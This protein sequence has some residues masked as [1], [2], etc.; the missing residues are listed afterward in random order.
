[1]KRLI[2]SVLAAVLIL[3]CL[4]AALMSGVALAVEEDI[5]VG[6]SVLEQN[7]LK[8]GAITCESEQTVTGGSAVT[9]S[10]EPFYGNAFIGWFDG[11]QKVSGDA[12][13]TF[14]AEEDV[15]LSARFDI[16]NQ[17][18]NGSL[19]VTAANDA[20]VSLYNSF[21][22]YSETKRGVA[23]V[24]ANASKDVAKYGAYSLE[25]TPNAAN[26][27]DK[28]KSL[29][30]FP[31]TVEKNKDY[32]WRFSYRNAVAG[33][34]HYLHYNIDGATIVWNGST[35]YD[36]D[37]TMHSRG[38]DGDWANDKWSW[39]GGTSFKSGANYYNNRQYEAGQWVD[40][41]IM[42]NSG[43]D[44]SVFGSS[45]TATMHLT[46][47]TKKDISDAV[48]L[49][50]LSFSEAV[51]NDRTVISHG[52]SV[53]VTNLTDRSTDAYYMYGL[54]SKG[55]TY[56]N[57]DT[58]KVFYPSIYETYTATHAEGKEFLGW[59]DEN[60]VLVA[61]TP[62]AQLL[63]T[64]KTY[65]PRYAGVPDAGEGGYI[66]F[67]G[68]LVTATPYYGNA[69]RGWSDGVN[70]ISTE[71]TVNQNSV[72][73]CTAIFE[74][75][76]LIIDGGFER[77]ETAEIYNNFKDY[78]SA[79]REEALIVPTFV[80]GS[81]PEFG[82]SCLVVPTNET[83]NMG[84]GKQKGL[85]N[86]PV[87]VEAGKTYLWKFSYTFTAETYNSAT[88]YL[89]FSVD[90]ETSGGIP[91]KDTSG[92]T[93]SFHYEPSGRETIEKN[94]WAWGKV[95]TSATG[96]DPYNE[97]KN[98]TAGDKWVNLYVFFTPAVDGVH[99]LSLGTHYNCLSTLVFDNMSVTAVKDNVTTSKAIAGENGSVRNWRAE[100]PAYFATLG[101]GE[102]DSVDFNHPYYAYMMV[103]YYAVPDVGYVFDGW[104][105][106]D[107]LV[108]TDKKLSVLSTEGKTYTAKFKI[109][110]SKYS[111]NAVIEGGVPFGGYLEGE[112]QYSEITSGGSVTFTAKPY[113]GNIFK[114]WYD[115]D[116]LL[117]T[118][119][120]FEYTVRANK[121]ITAKFDKKNLFPDSGAENSSDADLG[122]SDAVVSKVYAAT[123]LSSIKLGAPTT[124]ITHA[125][126]ALEKNKNYY[127]STMWKGTAPDYIKL[128]AADGSVIAE[129]KDFA[130]GEGWQKAEIV[131]NSGNND[132]LKLEISY[133][134]G[135]LYLD[136][137][138][139][140][141]A[142]LA[143]FSVTAEV[144]KVGNI[145]PGY[146]SSEK[147]QSAKYGETV[148]FTAVA[149]EQNEFLGWYRGDELLSS[150][151]TY[152][153]VVGCHEKIV[154]KFKANNLV[155]DSGAENTALNVSLSEG[156][157]QY[158]IVDTE[159]HEK[160]GFDV[161]AEQSD[162]THSGRTQYK[163]THRTVVFKYKVE[164]LE[165]NKNYVFSFWWKLYGTT[166]P[167]ANMTSI[168]VAGL[169]D[170]KVL[171]NGTGGSFSLNWQQVTVPF[172][173]GNNASVE[174]SLLYSAGNGDCLFDDI[175]LYESN[176]VGIY[177]G[178]GGTVSATKNGPAK[179]G[180]II[181]ATATPAAGNTFR[182]W[183]NYKNP[184]E[185]LSKDSEYTFTVTDTEYI[186]AYFDGADVPS[187]NYVVDGD[188]ENGVFEDMTFSSA[189]FSTEWCN[190]VAGKG[191]GGSVS[192]ISG[193]KCLKIT[194]H[195][196]YSNIWINNLKPNADYTLSFYWNGDPDIVLDWVM[197]NSYKKEHEGQLDQ[198]DERHQNITNHVLNFS[199][200]DFYS[201]QTLGYV[202]VRDT[203]NGDWK[204]IE[205]PF[206]NDN[207]T[208]ALMHFYYARNAGS[209]SIYLDDVKVTEGHSYKTA[210]SD[211]E[212]VSEGNS[213]YEDV[214][215]SRAT[216]YTLRFKAR[217]DNA[218][219]IAAGVT[220]GGAGELTFEKDGVLKNNALSNTSY[221]TLSLDDSWQEFEIDVFTNGFA[222]YRALFESENGA[223]FEIKDVSLD[224]ADKLIT[225]GKLGFES[226]EDTIIAEGSLHTGG[227]T[228]NKDY[229]EIDNNSANAHSGEAALV[230][231]ANGTSFV[232]HPLAQRWS[233]LK[234][235][236]GG[237]YTISLFVKSDSP[238]A[239]KMSAKTLAPSWAEVTLFEREVTTGA[240]WQEVSVTFTTGNL[241]RLPY[242]V[243][244]IIDAV[245]G[246]T[247]ADVRFDDITI[248]QSARSVNVTSAQNLYT[249]NIS[250]NYFE[251][252]GFEQKG[253]VF[254][255]YLASGDAFEG[256]NFLRVSAGDEIILPVRTRSDFVS[257]DF[258]ANFTFAAS[259]RGAAGAEGFVG[260]SY[261]ADGSELLCDADGN[262]VKLLA[263][264]DGKWSRSGFSFNAHR[265]TGLYLVIKC[266]AGSFDVDYLTLC[267]TLR[268]YAA[269]RS[270]TQNQTFDETYEDMSKFDIGNK[271]NGILSGL[272]EDS[273]VILKSASKTY[274]AKV[275]S[276]GFYEFSGI[277][278]G[279]Y[280]MFVLAG[281]YD[282]LT[283]WG[284][285]TLKE[286]KAN[287]AAC[288]RLYGTVAQVSGEAV[289]N[290]IVKIVDESTG[291]AYLTAT[292][293]EGF[294]DAFI[295]DCY[296]YIEGSTNA[297]EALEAAGLTLEDFGATAAKDEAEEQDKPEE[298]ETG[299]KPVVIVKPTQKSGTDYTWII[300]VAAAVVVLAGAT[301]LIVLLKKKGGKK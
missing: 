200:G 265:E 190:F 157:G 260:L 193:E 33:T 112:T 248:R 255:A 197:V 161:V 129:K 227:A 133:P 29:I 123:G 150:D 254:E 145:F 73:G 204:Y 88:D 177:A 53:S 48:L 34:I 178:E 28:Q 36:I 139:V 158:W 184:T 124:A 125:A 217:S 109:D 144:E 64:G 60:S 191:N 205:I 291:W 262:P 54:V 216:A 234:L 137:V 221:K 199:T 49:D 251:N 226:A 96:N 72:S 246:K 159:N 223:A 20:T 253:D 169:S 103:D 119:P 58:S 288:E 38:A 213:Y 113:D 194:S 17:I 67:E 107:A 132:S 155:V 225:I 27:A 179:T 43:S 268:A 237:T 276:T 24:K 220:T 57:L 56:A 285:I 236:S 256:E 275:D 296:Y 171:A 59:F 272:P 117:S 32:I 198:E 239:F 231:K 102:A 42:F 40:V 298:D 282:Y 294:Y 97:D 299:K 153:H 165:Q 8:G 274:K 50:N 263:A 271:I 94:V 202:T 35:A 210:V 168:K 207:R 41:F 283:L 45:D 269:D 128:L 16:R 148:T 183:Y 212:L 126:I 25:L 156:E 211:R 106:E 164:G 152:S 286:G 2:S 115:G 92:L 146:I 277:R 79:I 228:A 215:L 10:A 76:N 208:T 267:N 209:G 297:P 4:S 258:A 270:V 167:I 55:D 182:G 100:E 74:V 281:G 192:P 121:T 46:L 44:A 151:A 31:V 7:G 82:D 63:A 81:G 172:N 287:G 243:Y 14:I 280:R 142:E 189:Q 284:D 218:A 279:S 235:Q 162:W 134:S 120:T 80:S 15:T 37:W 30:S 229:F 278:D 85:L 19:E 65:R 295:L 245:E 149:Y 140:F 154:A 3:S 77:A 230:M 247:T 175:A 195:S 173:S 22:N 108:T 86:I 163:A 69:F 110:T 250:Q 101:K 238:S 181:T 259:L 52:S 11:A 84:A 290:G 12:S 289:V 114:G 78:S 201:S 70:I 23:A 118:E 127:F 1:M 174:I 90:K 180:D 160:W 214:F 292:S 143:E 111:A 47:G 21:P 51:A 136:D 242:E 266:S 224:L 89:V 300:I 252:Y 116:K 187:P 147:L 244:F 273:Y 176:Y 122:F 206:T 71:P 186:I 26:S 233:S 301:V 95:A 104:Y 9:V 83:T 141:D 68:D 105:L 87:T 170:Q 188:F 293:P 5:T 240:E 241:V 99:Y 222:G 196:R 261:A 93:Y 232:S 18:E 219:V 75:Y 249:D 203:A 39:E 185:L 13:Y 264:T 66:S 6:V 98:F 166:N 138:S 130:L 62:T 91:W 131:F 61:K 257:T 135:E